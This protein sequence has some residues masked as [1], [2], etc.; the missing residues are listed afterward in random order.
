MTFPILTLLFNQKF[1]KNFWGVPPFW[2]LK[3]RCL[4]KWAPQHRLW[5]HFFLCRILFY[6]KNGDVCKK[7]ELKM[8]RS[9]REMR[10][11]SSKNEKSKFSQNFRFFHLRTKNTINHQIFTIFPIFFFYMV[12]NYPLVL[13]MG[14]H[15]YWGAYKSPKKPKYSCGSSGPPPGLLPGSN[16]PGGKGLKRLNTWYFLTKI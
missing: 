11:I 5:P 13:Y 1:W 10:V 7:L 2:P 15:W 3:V 6:S 9:D 8:L 16:M 12:S 14:Q 4:Q